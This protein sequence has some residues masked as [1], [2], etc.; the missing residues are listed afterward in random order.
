MSSSLDDNG[1]LAALFAHE[2]ARIL[3]GAAA[4][5]R[6]LA[7]GSGFQGGELDRL[8]RA[9]HRIAGSAAVLAFE[10]TAA[11][12]RTLEQELTTLLATGE[13]LPQAAQARLRAD[14]RLLAATCASAAP[15]DAAENVAPAAAPAG[16]GEGPLVVQIEDDPVNA[17]LVERVLERRPHIRL[18]TF[19]EGQAGI[20][21]VVAARP[22]L[23]L[24]DLQLPDIPGA[25]VLRRL[26]ADERA[27]ATSGSSS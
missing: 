1:E 12:A 19:S 2:T 5:L 20:E 4:S 11:A 16:P 10:S 7:A 25:E 23:V 17:R 8:R 21:A 13:P 22:S 15:D 3:D 14:F 9:A 6:A 24:L 18:A 27:R 26:R